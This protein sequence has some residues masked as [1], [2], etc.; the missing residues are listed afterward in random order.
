MQSVWIMKPSGR[1]QGKGIFLINKISDIADWKDPLP[2]ADPENPDEK[3]STYIVQPGRA[4]H[5]GAQNAAVKVPGAAELIANAF[6]TSLVDAMARGDI[7]Q[8][9]IFTLIF[10]AACA[11]VGKGAGPVAAL[12]EALAAVAF[13]YTRFIMYA[14]P[15]AVFASMAVTVAE[16]GSTRSPRVVPVGASRFIAT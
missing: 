14:A 7:L 3:T 8:I 16:N 6:P 10:G 9:V 1:A 11:T 12:A 4:L 5:L 2:P 15:L 13:Q